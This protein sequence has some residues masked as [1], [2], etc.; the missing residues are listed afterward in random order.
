MLVEFMLVGFVM[1][2][3]E[4]MLPGYDWSLLEK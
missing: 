2:F 1:A 4:C 3:I